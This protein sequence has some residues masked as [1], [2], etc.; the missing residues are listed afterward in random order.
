MNNRLFTAGF[1]EAGQP[2]RITVLNDYLFW[3]FFPI[4]VWIDF[5]PYQDRLSSLIHTHS[6]NC[7]ADHLYRDIRAD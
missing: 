6:A 7:D 2:A 4:Y 1:R 3:D 5:Y